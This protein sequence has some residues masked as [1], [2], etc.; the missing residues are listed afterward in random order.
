VKPE[1]AR[2]L[3]LYV[4]AVLVLIGGGVWFFR[5]APRLGVDPRL[6]GWRATVTLAVPDV[7]PQVDADTLVLGNG[8]DRQATAQV[9]GGSFTLTMICAGTGNVRVRMSTGN[10]TGL[11][12]A[13][14]TRPQPVTITVGLGPQFFLSMESESEGAVFRWR[15]TQA[16]TY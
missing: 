8:T 14:A 11:A 2:G 6:A 15:L 16:S 13:C 1:R 4:L 7:Q 12:I 9:P 10:D 3:Q 5:A